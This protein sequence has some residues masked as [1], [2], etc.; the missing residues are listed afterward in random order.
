M[1]NGKVLHGN[2]MDSVYTLGKGTYV[3]RS[4]SIK[5]CI[6][7]KK[8]KNCGLGMR[9]SKKANVH[10]HLKVLLSKLLQLFGSLTDQSPKRNN[11]KKI[12]I[13]ISETKS[14]KQIKGK[15]NNVYK[16]RYNL[17]I[18]SIIKKL[19]L[20]VKT[21][22]LIHRTSSDRV[23]RTS[24]YYSLFFSDMLCDSRSLFLFRDPHILPTS[25]G[26][27]STLF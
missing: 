19:N 11:N 3:P 5:V 15:G 25:Y 4:T 1:F 9:S 13:Y 7:T 6:F 2:Q 16:I 21:I 27:I 26:Y 23:T 18:I 12:Y 14:K 8:I 24:I 22:A 20:S 17:Y 10:M